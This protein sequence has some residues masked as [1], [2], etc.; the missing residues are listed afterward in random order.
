[1]ATDEV[2]HRVTLGET[3]ESTHWKEEHAMTHHDDARL[4]DLIPQ[5]GDGDTKDLFRA[6]LQWGT[7][8]FTHRVSG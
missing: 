8:Y 5:L 3:C 1:M 2:G 6:L 7:S 4:D